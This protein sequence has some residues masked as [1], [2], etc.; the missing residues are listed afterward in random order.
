MS[1]IVTIVEDVVIERFKDKMEAELKELHKNGFK[2]DVKFSTCV[3]GEGDIIDN[4]ILYTAMII[5]SI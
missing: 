2:T 1:K 4:G 3:T 5:G